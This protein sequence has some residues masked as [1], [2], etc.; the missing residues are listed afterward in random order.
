MN[1]AADPLNVCQF[2]APNEVITIRL[3][4]GSEFITRTGPG[5]DIV[6]AETA[7]PGFYTATAGA[8]ELS[9]FAVNVDSRESETGE[10]SQPD[11]AEWLSPMNVKVVRNGDG[12]EENI[13]MKRGGRDVS[14]WLLLAACLLLL[15]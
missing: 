11:L 1:G 10:I 6:F 15:A 14:S 9:E 7:A 2:M 8:I 5:G 4:A 13:L 12:V 3:P